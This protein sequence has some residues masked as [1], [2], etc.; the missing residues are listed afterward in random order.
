MMR[1]TPVLRG[2]ILVLTA[3]AWTHCTIT[4]SPVVKGDL[5]L[6]PSDLPVLRTNG[7]QFVT[8]E[9]PPLQAQ[10][11]YRFPES[12]GSTDTFYM[13]F[14]PIS[15]EWKNYGNG[16]TGYEWEP[17]QNW[18][19]RAQ[20]LISFIGNYPIRPGVHVSVHMRPSPQRIDL[21]LAVTN[22]TQ[23]TLLGVWSDGG[24]LGA[25]SSQFFDEHYSRT[26]IMTSDG[27]T[28]LLKTDRSRGIRCRYL[29]NRLWYDAGPFTDPS[30]VSFWG[31]SNTHP[32]SPFIVALAS[33]GR[34][35]IGVGFDHS[36][37]L[38]QNS[39]SEH[40]CM[41]SCPFFGTLHPG[42]SAQRKGV[43]LLGVG[44]SELFQKFEVLHYRPDFTSP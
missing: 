12:V 34:G 31:R 14:E 6:S 29:F 10:W 40:H 43:I 24:C 35:A 37:G 3:L 27:L 13:T 19:E 21:S 16:E 38:L 7:S 2:Q 25:R 26:Y 1:S 28:P 4:V 20:K 30:L 32:S 23:R 22:L 33:N 39:D 11:L 8:V 42:E 9:Y 15:T 17:S 18:L 44:V 41:H 36:M 5:Q